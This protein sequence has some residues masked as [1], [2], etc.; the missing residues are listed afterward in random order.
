MLGSRWPL[1]SVGMSLPDGF[2]IAPILRHTTLTALYVDRI[3]ATGDASRC[4][5]EHIQAAVAQA[6]GGHPGLAPALVR[7][8]S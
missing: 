7:K 2:D 4:T 5:D 8:A 3:I 6:L 1:S